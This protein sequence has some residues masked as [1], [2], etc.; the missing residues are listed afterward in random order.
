MSGTKKTR[1][2]SQET[3]MLSLLHDLT[4]EVLEIKDIQRREGVL[5]KGRFDDLE[6]EFRGIG[7]RLDGLKRNVSMAVTLAGD[8]LKKV[9]DLHVKL[10][11]SADGIGKR[12][13]DLE[14][15]RSN[16]AGRAGSSDR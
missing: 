1:S 6:A 8:A 3:Q 14:K 9:N 13:H 4:N 5:I 12:L 10:I 16:R 7:R 15:E 2:V 11:G